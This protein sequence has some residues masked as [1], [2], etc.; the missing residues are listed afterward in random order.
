MNEPFSTEW[1]NQL[2]PP[3]PIINIIG[4][5]R[6]SKKVKSRLKKLGRNYELI[7]STDPSQRVLPKPDFDVAGHIVTC[8]TIT[9]KVLEDLEKLCQ[10]RGIHDNQEFIF[11]L[12]KWCFSD[13]QILNIYDMGVTAV[14]DWSTEYHTLNRLIAKSMKSIDENESAYEKRLEALKIRLSSQLSLPTTYI[15]LDGTIANIELGDDA[16]DKS[17]LDKIEATALTVPGVTECYCQVI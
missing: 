1:I 6:F 2:F 8:R 3:K 5:K 15:E 7:V 16:V 4:E 14:F 11:L 9:E 13:E 10:I 12:T 17:N